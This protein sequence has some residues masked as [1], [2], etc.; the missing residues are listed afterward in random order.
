MKQS[1]TL[2]ENTMKRSVRSLAVVGAV[3]AVALTISGCASSTT[4]SPT[5]STEKK[6]TI[7]FVMG[8]ESDPFFQAMK[9]GATEEAAAS[10][11]DLVWQGDPSH[12]DVATEVPIVESVIASKPDGLVLQPTQLVFRLHQTRQ[13]LPASLLQTLTP[14]PKTPAKLF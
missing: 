13:L 10:N 1:H 12:Y 3:A 6:L 8:A 2:G 5:A 14:T 4:P 7:A 9:V 11:V